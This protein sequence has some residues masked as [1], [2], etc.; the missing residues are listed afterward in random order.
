MKVRYEHPKPGHDWRSLTLGKEY[1]VIG[2]NDE[3]Y[4]VVNDF[5]EP[6]LYPKECF[7]I[8]DSR[9]PEDWRRDDHADGEY[10]IN[11]IEVAKPGFYEKFFDDV[12]EAQEVFRRVLERERKRYS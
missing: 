2:L 5:N 10:R 3:D 12:P 4:R 6:I 11:P 8:T 7:E 9:V 1:L